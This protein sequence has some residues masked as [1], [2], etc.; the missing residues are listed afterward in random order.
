MR[1]CACLARSDISAEQTALVPNRPGSKR[2]SLTELNDIHSAHVDGIPSLAE[3][4]ILCAI[5]TTLHAQNCSGLGRHKATVP[6]GDI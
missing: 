4:G 3:H 6:W 1:T 5:A 2:P